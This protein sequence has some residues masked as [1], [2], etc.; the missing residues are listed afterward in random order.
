M[1]EGVFLLLLPLGRCRVRWA[2][3]WGNCQRGGIN[4]REIEWLT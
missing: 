1:W 2:G 4:E 3:K